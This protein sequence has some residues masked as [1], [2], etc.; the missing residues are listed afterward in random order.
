MRLAWLVGHGVLASCAG[1]EWR[2]ARGAAG[3]FTLL[4]LD[5][6]TAFKQRAERWG[7]LAEEYEACFL[8]ALSLRLALYVT[9]SGPGPLRSAL[10]SA[11]P[12]NATLRQPPCTRRR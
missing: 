10:P 9:C 11:P 12:G 7:A 5:G 4:G 3:N 1:P 2:E 8:G 6:I